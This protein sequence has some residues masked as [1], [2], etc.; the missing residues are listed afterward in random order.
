MEMA[1]EQYEFGFNFTQKPVL[2]PMVMVACSNNS[3]IL[4]SHFPSKNQVNF[5][6]F[7]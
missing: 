2:E 6:I 4:N 1:C 7:M 3:P 5:Q